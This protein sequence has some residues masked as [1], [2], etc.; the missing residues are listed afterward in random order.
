MPWPRLPVLAFERDPDGLPRV[1]SL[2]RRV[3]CALVLLAT[4]WFG[5]A[6]AWEMFGPLLAGHYAASASVGIIAEN[7]LRWRILGP[8]WEYVASRPTPAQYYCH[9]PWEIFWTSAL[10]MKVFGR[11]DFVCRLPA[12]LLSTATVPLLFALGRAIWRPAAGAG[13]AVAFVVLPISLAFANFNAL[14]VPVIAWSLLGLW[15]YVRLT[16]TW[17]RRHLVASVCGFLLALN[18]DWPAFVL[19]GALLGFGLLRGLLLGR[20][21]FGAVRP[22]R[23]AQW[24]ALLATATAATALGYAL[25][26]HTSGKLDDL[27]QSYEMR[28]AGAAAPLAAVLASRRYWIELCFTP[29]AIALGKAAAVLCVLR[30]CVRR[31]EHEL[32]PLF[33]LLMAGVQYVAFKQGADIHVYWPHYFAA[34]FALGMAALAATG[35]GLAEAVTRLCA[36]RRGARGGRGPAPPSYRAQAIALAAVLV[37][38]LGALALVARDGVPALAYARGTGG[39]FNEKGLLIHSDGAKTAFLR[40]L[41]PQLARDASVGMH[42]GMKTTW[43]QV[44]ALGG[45][46]VRGAR[47]LPPAPASVGRSPRHG[48]ED[49]YL[50]DTRFLLDD[51]QA[52]LAAEQH[53]VA[54]GPFW[55]ALA[56]EP[57]APLDAYSF[58]ES[59]P[60][61]WHWYLVSGTEPVR[62]VV[63]DPFL[64][65]EL[66]T[67]FGQPADP[68]A[69]EPHS[70][71]QI[72]IAHNVAVSRG[73]AAS[74]AALL[75][76]LIESMAGPRVRFDDGTELLGA[77]YAPGA[78]PLLTLLV[79]AAGPATEDIQLAVRSRVVRRARFSTT[80]AD[81]TTRPV[82]IPLGLAP[83]RW[84][85]GFVYSDLVPIRKR[86]GTEVFEAY[87]QIRGR[88]KSRHAKAPE[89]L[90]HR[91]PV[92]VLR[93]E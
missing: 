41:V 25:L 29:V 10:V 28:S 15:G 87:F 86:P 85:A 39:R 20:R 53:V 16:Q 6:A 62:R 64:T 18:A 27:L 4:A 37:P 30:L 24:W 22:L 46:I 7:M 3:S 19:V 11:H 93:L 12:V 40:W 63:P 31:Y 48:G 72:R 58:E 44:W 57:A 13:A 67:H 51:L 47:P 5:L 45:R 61:F 90:G 14:E 88:P 59:E 77:R 91:G 55:R 50:A 23:Y 79:R 60:G 26:F 89:P 81:P 76:R 69:A 17:K 73:D 36:R 42:E 80:M 2:E 75:G 65:W 35:L 21:P 54:V 9:H 92:A 8:V 78:R 52:R 56:G 49:V 34:F 74:A 71:E 38:V 33:V 32:V 83:L 66:R 1:G 68:P 70:L 84:R 43:A 82:G